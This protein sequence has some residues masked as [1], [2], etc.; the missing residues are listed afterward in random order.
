MDI[1]IYENRQDAIRKIRDI[2]FDIARSR[3][4][5]LVP[6]WN[7]G[8]RAIAGEILPDATA[9]I[10]LINMN[11]PKA[12][13]IARWYRKHQPETSI[14][15]Y[16]QDC[17]ELEKWLVCCYSGYSSDI[18][19]IRPELDRLVCEALENQSW[20]HHMNKQHFFSLPLRQII[21]FE[22]HLRNVNLVTVDGLAYSYIGK[23]DD[24][25]GAGYEQR[26]LRLH[27][28]HLVNR[29]MIHKIDLKNR[30]AI[31]R[32]HESIPIS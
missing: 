30:M 13:D 4:V 17:S 7:S 2:Q 15:L 29:Q 18:E 28:S 20:F 23:L 27:K 14:L 3:K 31:L 9:V 16:G 11:L 22:S 8:P 24:L 10:V 12:P 6:S 1:F 25:R 5:T 32:N 21:R 26:F 19:G